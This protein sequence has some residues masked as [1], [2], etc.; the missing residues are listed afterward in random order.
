M[1]DVPILYFDFFH[2]DST[3]ESRRLMLKV[4]NKNVIECI[5]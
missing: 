1:V 3:D 4:Y 2:V 5:L